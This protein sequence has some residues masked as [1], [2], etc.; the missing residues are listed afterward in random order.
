MLN[1]KDAVARA[2]KLDNLQPIEIIL[3]LEEIPG[4]LPPE[5][6]VY[7]FSWIFDAS[8]ILEN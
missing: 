8:C 6:N 7:K 5:L 1:R 2:F 3:F 4:R